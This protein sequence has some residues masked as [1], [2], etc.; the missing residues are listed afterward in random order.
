MIS[1]WFWDYLGVI[2]P[3]TMYLP[4]NFSGWFWR[5]FRMIW[6]IFKDDFR[7]ILGLSPC[8]CPSV[9]QG[10]RGYLGICQDV[11]VDIQR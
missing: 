10:Q 3:L 1:E 9:T 8:P 6:G 5:Y 7:M 2:Y 4:Q 11:F